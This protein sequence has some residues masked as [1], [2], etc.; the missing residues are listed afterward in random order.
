MK[1]AL[2]Y[3]VPLICFVAL[4]GSNDATV[5]GQDICAAV[6]TTMHCADPSVKDTECI[7]SRTA[8]A[9]NG[10]QRVSKNVRQSKPGQRRC[11]ADLKASQAPTSFPTIWFNANPK[12]FLFSYFNSARRLISLGRLII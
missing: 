11:S 1:S 8:S 5:N 9:V 6:E 4:F 7:L 2:K 12:P 10:A 3:I